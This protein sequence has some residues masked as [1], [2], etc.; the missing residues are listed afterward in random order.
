MKK[1]L[2]TLL[3]AAGFLFP[4]TAQLVQTR[5]GWQPAPFKTYE[6]RQTQP[7]HSLRA[8]GE[9]I[10]GYADRVELKKNSGLGSNKSANTFGGGFAIQSE[11]QLEGTSIKSIHVGLAANTD[12]TYPGKV[13]VYNQTSKQMATIQDA[14]LTF[15]WHE[16]QLNTPVTIEANTTYIV[17]YV[18]DLPINDYAIGL[19]GSTVDPNGAWFV[20][21]AVPDGGTQKE[22]LFEDIYTLSKDKGWG[23]F[24]VRATLA[25]PSGKYADLFSETTLEYDGRSL[26][27]K[28]STLKLFGFNKGSSD[29]SSV[30]IAV[31]NSAGTENIDLTLDQPILAATDEEVTLPF[32]YQFTQTGTHTF[33]VTK[34]NG[35]ENTISAPAK[36]IIRE[37]V[38]DGKSAQK[39]GLI[40]QFTGE[41]CPYCP[42]GGYFLKELITP[43]MEND[44]RPYNVLAYHA[45]DFLETEVVKPYLDTFAPSSYPSVIINRYANQEETA[46][47]I[48]TVL[49]VPDLYQK[50]HTAID[51]DLKGSLWT[52]NRNMS[53]TAT[54][55]TLD[56]DTEFNNLYLTV[57]LVEDNIP[58]KKQENAFPDE[59]P[60]THHNNTV[61][62]L[63]TP[64]N[65]EAI[66][67]TGGTFTK[68]Y[69]IGFPEGVPF[70]GDT[71][72]LRI[73]AYVSGGLTKDKPID[74]FIRNSKSIDHTQ[75]ITSICEPKAVNTLYK[76]YAID[77]NVQVEGEYSYYEVYNLNGTQVAGTLTPG[78]YV[79]RI[80]HQ[81]ASQA[82]KL[83]VE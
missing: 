1:T 11:D 32:D 23:N 37:L 77:G 81:G 44:G 39:T 61:V 29:I 66:S 13:F 65:G 56:P 6:K 76:V 72:N 41:W 59:V 73:V 63:F 58:V 15:G 69:V 57:V 27:D 4:A 21:Y 55:K 48:G 53:V 9:F 82:V 80:Y 5:P 28:T 22:Y 34:V 31:T 19:D 50:E 12:N 54:V 2:L 49:E 74:L 17:G 25:D 8:S 43:F 83:L 71:K 30:T 70:S 46:L 3:C 47:H 42:L 79:V 26:L 62:G 7:Q 40:E 51:I 67:L 20:Q 14:Q 52:T 60:Y 24:T 78:T 35:K 36:R 68:E 38:R 75:I 18:I 10:F 64:F 45:G 33:A 16:Y